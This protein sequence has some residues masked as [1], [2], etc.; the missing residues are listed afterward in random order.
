MAHGRQEAW[1][2]VAGTVAMW[3]INRSGFC[4][5]PVKAADIIPKQFHPRP[6]PTVPKSEEERKRDQQRAWDD[7]DRAFEVN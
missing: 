1:W 5:Q 6:P 7:F 3:V 4:P 2:D